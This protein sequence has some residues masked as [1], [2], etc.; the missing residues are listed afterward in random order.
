MV[1]LAL[2][3]WAM[4][5]LVSARPGR[6]LMAVEG[7]QALLILAI[8]PA[9]RLLSFSPWAFILLSPAAGFLTGAEFPLAARASVFSGA[10]SGTVAGGLDATDHLGA[11]VGAACAGLVLVPALG[12][13]RTAALLA[14]A[15]CFSVLALLAASVLTVRRAS[16]SAPPA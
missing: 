11:L 15:K 1:G 9:G 14:L 6:A 13:A 10:D 5:R 7:A 2:G 12:L 4:N 16:V 8:V 3:G